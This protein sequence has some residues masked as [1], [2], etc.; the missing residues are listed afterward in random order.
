MTNKIET[1]YMSSQPVVIS[2]Q[3][4]QNQCTTKCS[5]KTYYFDNTTTTLLNTGTSLQ[6]S[7]NPNSRIE[8]NGKEYTVDCIS[9]ICPAAQKFGT[10]DNS[11][12]IGEIIIEHTPMMGGNT[13]NVA[14]PLVAS[15]LPTDISSQISNVV[16]A[17]TKKTPN[18]NATTSVA[19]VLLTQLLPY[20][21]SYF[22]YT[23]ETAHIDWFVFGLPNAIAVNGLS[24]LQNII[25][26]STLISIPMNNN[27][28]RISYNASGAIDGNSFGSSTGTSNSNTYIQCTPIENTATTASTTANSDVTETDNNSP[29]KK[30][31]WSIEILVIGIT[32]I[33]F[34]L[35][36]MVYRMMIKSNNGTANDVSAELIP[37][38]VFK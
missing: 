4:S 14:I 37:I 16:S 38:N 17:A 24:N 19:S 32:V 25:K 29:K 8:S 35:G 11:S 21:T 10:V 27:P 13:L 20:R 34:A 12:V 1:S 15:G 23:D 7:V 9:I 22:V 33:V 3:N 30:N 31:N 2:A 18:A 26:P 28:M 5:L 6:L 36:Y